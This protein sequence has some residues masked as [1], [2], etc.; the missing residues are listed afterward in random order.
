MTLKSESILDDNT[1]CLAFLPNLEKIPP[2]EIEIMRILFFVF[3]KVRTHDLRFL[4]FKKRS[5]GHAK[6]SYQFWYKSD[7]PTTT[8]D[9][10]GSVGFEP[11]NSKSTRRRGRCGVMKRKFHSFNIR[12]KTLT[13]VIVE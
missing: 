10:A 4:R 2:K 6:G 11:N 8:Y 7:H 1:V 5:L 12:L 13:T 3:N 9:D